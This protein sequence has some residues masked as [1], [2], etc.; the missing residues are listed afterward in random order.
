[1]ENEPCNVK[2]LRMWNLILRPRQ[3]WKDVM[4]VIKKLE[5]KNWKE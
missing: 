1:L 3:R 4:E 5:V 2:G